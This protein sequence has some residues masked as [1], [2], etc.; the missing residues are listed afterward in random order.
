[1]SQ[2]SRNW[3]V[4]CDGFF[5]FLD[6]IRGIHLFV[7]LNIWMLKDVV[8]LKYIRKLE[9]VAALKIFK[10]VNEASSS[11]PRRRQ[12]KLNSYTCF[13]QPVVVTIRTRYLATLDF[14]LGISR[15]GATN[16]PLNHFRK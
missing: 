3:Q 2:V 6:M 10:Q 7:K 4:S 9:S 15:H 16:V 1:M 13:V 14:L 5:K 11:V 8:V 12:Y